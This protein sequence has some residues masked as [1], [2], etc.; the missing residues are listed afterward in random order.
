VPSGD[1]VWWSCSGNDS[2]CPPTGGHNLDIALPALADVP[3]GLRALPDFEYRSCGEIQAFRLSGPTFKRRLTISLRAEKP[4][5]IE[6]LR[7]G[8]V[9]R[10][11][12]GSGTVRGLRRGRYAVRPGGVT[13]RTRRV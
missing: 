13:L 8:K 4:V 6:I 1:H 7:A 12:G 9:V 5:P 11:L 10:T 3:A 2:G